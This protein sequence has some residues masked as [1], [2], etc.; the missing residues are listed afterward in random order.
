MARN[1]ER[2]SE[3]TSQIIPVEPFDFIVFGGTG[4]L[5]ERKLIPALYQRQRSGQFSEPTRIIGA[6]RTKLSD[7]DFRAFARKAIAGHVHDDD[8]DAAEIEAFVGRLS[9]VPV[10]AKAG[11]GFDALKTAIGDSSS[12]RVFYLAVAPGLFGDIAR[13]LDRQGL[14]LPSTRIVV[15]KPIGRSLASACDLND[16]I[17]EVFDESRSTAST[18]TSARRRCRT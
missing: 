11:E 3:M 9:Y 2:S 5:A 15:E 10:D 4:D 16:A 1:I 17:G 7:E 6:S 12:I 8:Q 13:N 14:A 18:T